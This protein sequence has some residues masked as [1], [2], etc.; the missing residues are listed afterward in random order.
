MHNTESDNRLRRFFMEKTNILEPKK[1]RNFVF[2]GFLIP[3]VGMCLMYLLMGLVWELQD[4]YFLSGAKKVFSLLNSDAYHQYFPFFKAFRAN[5]LSG[6][7]LIYCWDIGMG[8][9]FLGLYA[10]YLGSP[11]NWLSILIPE[12]WLL[13]FFTFLTP[14]R[15]GFA[16]MF[17]ALF[18]S[19]LFDR[20]DLSIAL[21]GSFYAT[22]AWVFGYLWN[23]MW[24]DT[25]ALLPLVVL[26]TVSLLKERK[27]I[28]YTISL[29]FS[30]FINYYIGFFTCIFTLLVFICYEICRWKG[31]VRFLADLCLMG[32]FTVI[33][34][35][36]T[37]VITL[38]AYAALLTT[39]AGTDTASTLLFR[40]HLTER[41]T[42]TG[43]DSIDTWLG[44]LEGMVKVAT[45]TF[46]YCEPNVV[47]SE[48]LPNVYCGVF[49]NFFAFLFITC[50]QVKWRDRICAV[51]MLLFFN[52]SFVI[53]DLNYIWHGFHEPNMIPYRFSFLYSFVMLYMAYRAF[54]LRRRIK[55]WQIITAGVMMLLMLLCSQNFADHLQLIQTPLNLYSLMNPNLLYPYVNLLFIGGYVAA[56][57]IFTIRKPLVPD[58]TK[59]WYQKLHF[60]RSLG[61]FCLICIL[62]A[63]F[64]LNIAFFSVSSS[65]VVDVAD[66]P[67]GGSDTQQVIAY[68]KQQ[69]NDL[70]YRAETTHQQIF[71]DS[72]LNGYSGI[73]TFTSSANVNVTNYLRFLG[74]GAFATYNRYCYED[75]SPLSNLF[76]NVKY[77]IERDG[78]VRENPYFTDIYQSGNVHLLENNQYLPLGFLVDPKLAEV[79]I[80]SYGNKFTMQNDFL[81]SALGK[82]VSAWQFFTPDQLEITATGNV[83]FPTPSK[84]TTASCDY[85]STGTGGEVYFTYTA[86]KKGFFCA[87]FS[88]SYPI[89]SAAPTIK[90]YA[91]TGSG[92]SATPLVSDSYSLSYVLSACQVKAGDKIKIAITCPANG[93]GTF[94]VCGAILDQSVMENAYT[95]LSQSTLTLTKFEDTLVEGT[96]DCKQS[97]L[98]YT[99]IPQAGG[100][101]R[102]FV[103][104]TEAEI[105][106][107]G[108]AMIGVMLEEGH[109]TVI[110]RYE[111]KAF[112]FGLVISLTCFMLFA[113][114]SGAYLY[115]KRK[116]KF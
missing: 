21:F 97:G 46:A 50:K 109:H 69:E 27:F 25:F 55:P 37:A 40:L 24:L 56:M 88:L 39:N 68:M 18:L 59:L 15:L 89:S 75:S 99:S 52:A 80:P 76:L 20:N 107:I 32:I 105:T 90:I 43:F 31:F 83:T 47:R 35:G 23:T 63:E 85:T 38:P 93:S 60:R 61:C 73:T 78:I 114:I 116:R 98:M 77:M 82:T 42:Q 96:I 58:E 34:L 87:S 16:G 5:I 9:D 6:K 108:N 14:V 30:V 53:N 103:D 4:S 3:F 101:W 70:F 62:A 26:G 102:V 36:M 112:T 45:N 57:L 100:N 13:D 86:D 11:L 54:L 71:N 95:Q 104:G 19:K 81:S 84:Y 12:S 79:T 51:F 92:F 64:I 48:G 2:W 113:C 29:F 8:T 49:A 22:C 65:L 10:Y 7:S 66:Y 72:A 115:H 111:N 44:L 17:F 67:K 28:L 41:E 33:A 1:P 94:Q 110:F 106:M 91:D 74:Y